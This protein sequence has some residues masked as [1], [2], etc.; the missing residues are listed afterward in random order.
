MGYIDK[1]QHW[2]LE[3]VGIIFMI[4]GASKWLYDI[5]I[6]NSVSYWRIYFVMIIAGVIMSG[7]MK[8]G[9]A[10]INIKLGHWRK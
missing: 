3:T 9:K 7:Y 4:V 10:L 6:L 5:V 8:I 2:V 1:A